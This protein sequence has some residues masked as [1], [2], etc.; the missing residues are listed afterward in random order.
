[1][2][3]LNVMDRVYDSSSGS[4][5]GNG[6]VIGGGLIIAGTSIG[7]GMLSLPIVSAGLGFTISAFIIVG[8]WA[9]MTYTSLLMLEVH[10]FADSKATL[11]TL[12]KQFLGEKGKYIAA[13]SMFFLFYALCAAYIAGGGSQITARLNSALSMEVHNAFGSIIFAIIVA[14]VVAIGTHFLD[15]VNRVLFILMIGSM[16]LVLMSL[17]PNVNGGFLASMPVEYGLVLTALP[18]VFTSFGFHGSI[19]AIVS[20][21][22]GD[23]KNL[24]KA[25]YIGSCL[26]LAIYVLWLLCTLGVVSQAELYENSGLTALIASLSATLDGSSLSTFINLF[27]ELALITSFLGVS[28]GLFDFIRDTTIHKLKGNKLYVAMLTYFPPLGFALFYPEGFIMALGYAAIALV[29][30]AVFL[31]VA[32]VYKSR[33]I[34][35]S[36]THY[37][38]FGGNALLGLAALSGI[39]II[40]SQFVA[41]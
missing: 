10:Q 27:A 23:T 4:T 8:L 40:I 41:G 15:K 25:M 19:P 12:A 36:G 20:Y 7:A 29:V 38:V 31:P 18:V 17:M 35:N 30:L 37:Q 13:F 33:Q 22:D 3:E 6:K 26:P 16:V 24:K 11:H 21:L 9:L 2:K 39:V 5:A 34:N 1:M 32:M 14:V 28:L